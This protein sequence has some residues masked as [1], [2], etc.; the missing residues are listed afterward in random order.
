MCLIRTLNQ[1]QDQK[2]ENVECQT[3]TVCWY[4]YAYSVSVLEAGGYSTSRSGRI[5]PETH[6]AGGSVEL[7][8][9]LDKKTIEVISKSEIMREYMDTCQLFLHLYRANYS[10]R[11]V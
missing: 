11:A 5:N 1:I 10:G 3:G 6:C 8:V 9:T 7:G 2:R 4:W